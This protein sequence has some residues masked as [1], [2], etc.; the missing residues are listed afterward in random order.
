MRSRVFSM[1]S[2]AGLLL[3]A[4]A[5]VQA[6]DYTGHAEYQ[7]L[8]YSGTQAVSAYAGGF[9]LT[10]VGVVLNNTEDWLNPAANYNTTKWNMG[11][12]AQFVIQAVPGYGVAGDSGGT[13]VY[14][15]Q[16]YGNTWRGDPSYSYTNE[17]W[18]AR[19]AELNLYTGTGSTSGTLRAGA[20][21]K[22]TAQTGTYY[23]GKE[24]I[25]ENHDKAA[26]N[27]FTIE[28]L[29]A[30]YGLPMA[31]LLGL[32]ELKNAD[33]SFIFDVTRATGDEHYQST[34]VDLCNVQ[35]TGA[36]TW[37][38]N[39]FVTV[40]D[41]QGRTFSLNLGRNDSFT[42]TPLV[43]DGQWFSV[44]GILNQEAGG[45]GMDGYRLLVTNA[46]A[47]VVPEPT[48]LALLAAALLAT[49]SARHRRQ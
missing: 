40:T 4:P 27:H 38:P 15:A 8:T 10:L 31:P 42:G 18:L 13:A 3:A 23:G 41:G 32:A 47:F 25:N 5:V 44:T 39:S 12:Q 16:N 19:L 24:N 34:L 7:S 28:V 14:L 29:D 45:S 1:V 33:D 6:V 20:L 30:D 35:I 17:E 46:D 22:V 2:T 36:A 37:L 21:V 48:A 11:G 43:A 49:V 9:P 26:A